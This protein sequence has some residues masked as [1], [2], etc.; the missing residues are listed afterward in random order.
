MIKIFVF[1]ITG[2]MG[3][4]ILNY[5]KLN[6]GFILLGG[7]NKNNYYKLFI[8]KYTIIFNKMKNTSVLIDFSNVLLIK[9][10]LFISKK[11]KI[12]I[13]IGVTGLHLKLLNYIK[14]SSKYISIL[15]SYNMSIGIN[16]INLFL[17]NTNNYLKKYNFESFI[18]DIHHDKKI[19]SPSGTALMLFSKIRKINK[20][21]LSI[22]IKN[23]IGN[24]FIFLISNN[25]IIKIEHFV[26]NRNIFVIGIFYSILWLLN[27]K[28]GCFSMYDIFF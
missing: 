4:S 27:T 17:S 21:I 26:L 28:K 7:V 12:P 6:K 18:L 16:I 19:D 15:L 2:K 24:H 11:F 1:G 10:N 3:K 13:I 14:F 5:I 22:R 20:N 25:E 8:N 23:I 9:K